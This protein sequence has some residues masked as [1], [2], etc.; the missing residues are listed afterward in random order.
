M[1]HVALAAVGMYLYLRSLGFRVYSS[2]FGAV[3]FALG[4]VVL[5]L[6]NLLP[7]LTSIAW[8][9]WILMYAR[10]VLR[11]ESGW[12]GLT[13]TVA[14]L[15]LA[16]ERSMMGDVEYVIVPGN[17]I[18]VIRRPT[19]PRYYFADQL[20]PIRNREEFVRLVS[21]NTWSDRVAFVSSVAF[22]PA[23]GEV[24]S[25]RESADAADLRV[26]S[27]G[28]SLLVISVTPHRYWRA[29]I[30]GAPASIE[31]ANVGFQG[32]VLPP[33]Q[34]NVS[35]RYRNPWIIACGAL[36]LL[37]LIAA[38]ALACFRKP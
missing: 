17:P 36:S 14:M 4:G 1:L 16:A 24:L 25:V 2:L 15:L 19:L 34:H 13:L 7:F 30:D 11:G 9:P 29:T 8:W 21:T 12:L 33:R 32:L 37:S 23:V 20:V 3:A 10:R 27:D 31:T 22:S 18:R 35:L 28:M 38:V 5:S 26:S 6:T